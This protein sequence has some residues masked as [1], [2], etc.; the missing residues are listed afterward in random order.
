[1]TAFQ[2]GSLFRLATGVKFLFKT[3]GPHQSATNPQQATDD[4]PEDLL[5]TIEKFGG[6]E[7][8][9][10]GLSERSGPVQTRAFR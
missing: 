5:Q 10:Y 1:M 4:I 2:A 3:N 6:L 7:P 9:T 8:L